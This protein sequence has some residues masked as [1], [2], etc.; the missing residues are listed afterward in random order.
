MKTTL[1]RSVALFAVSIATGAMLLP[2]VPWAQNVVYPKEVDRRSRIVSDFHSLWGV[3]GGRRDMRH[4]GIDIRGPSGQP[5][6]AI[7]DGVVVEAHVEKCMGPTIAIDHGRD[8]QG[9]PLIALYGHVGEMLV[10]RGQIVSRGELVARL[11]NNHRKF[12]C[13]S[14]VRHLHLQLGRSHRRSGKLG[15]WGNA[16]FLRDWNRA[17][18]PHHLWADGPYQVTCFDENRD[19]PSGTLTYPVPCRADGAAPAAPASRA[20]ARSADEGR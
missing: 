18:N 4:Q 12:K 15:W 16:Y 3:S 2:G 1:F 6:I 19:Y 5:V 14:G 9:K 8:T 13:I 17:L 7:A 11:G 20:A 10:T